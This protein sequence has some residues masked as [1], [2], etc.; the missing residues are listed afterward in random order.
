MMVIVVAM[1]ILGW[2]GAFGVSHGRAEPPGRQV[3]QLRTVS[4]LPC[5]L[6]GVDRFTR[7]TPL[8]VMRTEGYHL[9]V[10]R[11]LAHASRRP[12]PD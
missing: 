1:I 9:A 4:V 8:V 3:Y 2:V 12:V 7:A 6:A 10:G 11:S 5:A